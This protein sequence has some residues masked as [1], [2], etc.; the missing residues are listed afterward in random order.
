MGKKTN[1]LG[2]HHPERR[3]YNAEKGLPKEVADLVRTKRGGLKK[4]IKK[5]HKKKSRD[6]SKQKIKKELNEE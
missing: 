1:H 6:F 3:S 5:M 4:A 2:S